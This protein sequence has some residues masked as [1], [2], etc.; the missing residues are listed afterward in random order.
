MAARTP[1]LQPASQNQNFW[2][3]YA[4]D[5]GAGVW[6]NGSNSLPGAPGNPLS[7]EQFA[8]IE[9]GDTAFTSDALSANRGMFVC[10]DAPTAATC[11]WRRLDS[12]ASGFAPTASMFFALMPGDNA[13]PI[14][15]GAAVLFPQVGP[16]IGNTAPIA[17]TSSTFEVPDAGL[18]QIS[19]QCDV[20]EAA[21]LMLRV[22]GGLIA[23]SVASRAG[24]TVQVS[25][26]VLVQLAAGAVVEV[27][28]PPGNGTALT[29]TPADGNLTHSV[30]ASLTIVRVG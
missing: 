9:P 29:M 27:I 14:A 24:L 4:F 23:N 28:N 15:A 6:A 25:N 12:Q 21:Q 20:A 2:G 5:A 8:D 1:G 7:V 17:L 16:T 18:Y 26:S 11:E 19:W 22:N 30:G 3:S 13:A 10:V